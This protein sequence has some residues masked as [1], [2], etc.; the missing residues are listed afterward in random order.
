MSTL[1]LYVP[2]DLAKAAK[3][4]AIDQDTSVSAVVTQ[5]LRAWVA[6]T[7]HLPPDPDTETEQPPV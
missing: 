3:K 4:K 2:A 5:F 7:I 6:G 1:N